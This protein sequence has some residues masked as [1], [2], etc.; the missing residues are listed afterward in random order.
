MKEKGTA[1]IS[2]IM[3]SA[4]SLVVLTGAVLVV[5]IQSRSSLA[6]RQNTQGQ[7]LADFGVENAAIRLL[8]DP[9][10]AGESLNIDSN[11][12][13]ISVAASKINSSAKVG[14][15]IKMVESGFQ[16]NNNILT[17]FSWQSVP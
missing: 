4:I 17:I 9:N 14:Q 15:I 5:V 13:T 7:A 2:L 16:Y 1:L 12:V 10:Y 11:T 6:V 8:R 3:T